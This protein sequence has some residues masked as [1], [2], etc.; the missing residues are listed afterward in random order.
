MADRNSKNRAIFLDRDGVV[1]E[2]IYYRD[3]GR[4][5]SPFTVRQFRLL[6]GAAE[7]VC[8][9]NSLN[10][11]TVIVSNQPGIAR[12]HFT[13][14][15]LVATDA[16]MKRALTRKKAHLDAVYY[17]PHDPNGSNKRY[18]KVCNCRKPKPGLLLQ[19]AKRL[20]I[21]LKSS[22]MI[23]DEL[24]DI[25]AGSRAGCKTILMGKMKCQQ[26]RLMDDWNIQPDVIL[27][28]LLEAAKY[29]IKKESQK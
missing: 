27:P 1:N 23:G 11:K 6:P 8:I 17:C 14:K 25:E 26:C 18:R 10:F 16:K 12:N 29:I 15:T 3:I 13:K 4:I 19:A 28:S 20:N 5:D 21:D 22:Y 7:A 9:F 24:A 2:L